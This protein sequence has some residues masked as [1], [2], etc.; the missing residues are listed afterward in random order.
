MPPYFKTITTSVLDTPPLSSQLFPTLLSTMSKCE[1][2]QPAA[3]IPCRLPFVCKDPRVIAMRCNYVKSWDAFAWDGEDPVWVQAEKLVASRREALR[4]ASQNE[5][6]EP[7]SD[8]VK[9]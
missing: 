4:A 2:G 8:V 5:D 3:V 9:P 1:I 7:E 6:K